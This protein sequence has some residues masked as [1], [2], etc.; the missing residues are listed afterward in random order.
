MSLELDHVFIC[1]EDAPAAERALA[2]FGM[3]FDLHAIHGG[4]G[5]ANACAFFDNAYLELLSR[6]DDQELQS[7]AV[8]PLALW[9]RV[10]WRQTGA[11]PFGIAFRTENDEVSITTWPYEAAFLPPGKNIPIVTA[12]NAGHEPLVFLI[13]PTLPI[14]LRT[15]QAH[16]GKHR[17]LTR[18]TVSGPRVSA[19]PAPVSIL[20][21]PG[22]LAIRQAPEHHLE[23]DWDDASSGESHDFRPTLPLVLRW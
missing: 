1:V 10:R 12:P 4:Q 6:Q 13:P 2:D 11:S 22:L 23:L 15:P 5:T 14:R 18:V 8:R 19:L 16:R 20:Y 9:E 21:D 7:A 17:R 3:Q